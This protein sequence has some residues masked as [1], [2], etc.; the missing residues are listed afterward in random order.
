MNSQEAGKRIEK[1]KKEINYHRYLY[2]VLDKIEISDAAL[3]SLKHELTQLENQFPNLITSDSPTQRVG[4]QPLDKF[5]KAAHS[6]PMLSLEDA[7]SVEEM[8]AWEKRI[9]KIV[10]SDKLNYFAELKID[11]FAVSLIY[12]DGI[13]V[14][15]STRGDGLIG[16]NVTQ[17]LKTIESIPLKLEKNIKNE[18]E[19]RGEVFM[20]IKVFEKINEEQKKKGLEPYAN[21]R[22]IAAGSI[23][24]LDSKIAASRKLDFLAYDVISGTTETHEDKHKICQ[25]LGFKTDKLARSCQ[26]L[27]EVVEF[28]QEINKKR[29][30]LTYQIDGIVVSVNN[31]KIFEKLGVAGKAPRGAIAFKFPGKEATTIVEDIKISIGRTGVLTPIAHLKPVLIHGTTV[32]RATL[33]NMD[34]IKRLGIKIGDTVVVQRAGD[35]IPDIVKVLPNLRAGQEKEFKMPVI[36]CGQK[37]VKLKNEV[38]HKILNP[39]KCELV[40]RE[41]IDHFVSKKGFDIIGLGPKIIEH[42]TKES[43]IDSAADLF[44]L[45]EGD[46]APLERFGEKSAQNIISSIQKAK[47]I[48]LYKFIYALGIFHVGEETAIDLANNFS[49]LEKLKKTSLDELNKIPNIGGVIA[50]SIYDWFHK[51]ENIE[52]LEKLDKAGIQITYVRRQMS[53]AANVIFVLTGEM[54]S[55]T[56]EAAKIK[57]RE[58]GGK[59]SES[60][61]KKTNYLV[62]GSHPGSKYEKAKQLGVKIINEKEF[63]KMLTI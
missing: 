33:H 50:K 8:Q 40:Q 30:K 13:F 5:K 19:I 12:K 36:F 6:S 29:E 43:L 52:F 61:S 7:F 54:E 38:A 48:P 45:K 9:Q 47:N 41:K 63:L 53:D 18:I 25:E 44:E 49:S 23:R 10:S 55:I 51:T 39:E 62:A 1:L 59:I 3:D 26:D 28:W 4:G 27:K 15:G 11:G 14:D 35:V 24:Q 57:I 20:T 16:E 22:N 17:N 31:N 2:H 37:V 21:P 60:V 34:E 58:S 56:R 46:L 42:L 32:S